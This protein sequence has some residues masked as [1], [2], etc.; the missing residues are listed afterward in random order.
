MKKLHSRG[1]LIIL[2]IIVMFTVIPT[3]YASDSTDSTSSNVSTSTSDPENAMF[4][5]LNNLFGGHNDSKYLTK[6]RFN[7]SLD[8]K[9]TGFFSDDFIYKVFNVIA[10][11]VFKLII[12][13]THV[14][15]IIID[16]AFEISFVQMF[17]DAISATT[18]SLQQNLFADLSIA[19]ISLL[20]IFYVVKIVREQ[21]TQ[22]WVAI[23]ETLIILTFS[24][25]FFNN[26]S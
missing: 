5:G 14:L 9:K 20:G 12:G 4:S 21:K 2:M 3:A 7:Y 1:M 25:F 26:P 11:I 13:I 24:T 15:I 18:T 8:L 23:I 22:V 10:I 17:S 19:C 16:L 6:Y